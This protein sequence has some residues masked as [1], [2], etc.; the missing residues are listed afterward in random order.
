M[1][2]LRIGLER[3]DI[4]SCRLDGIRHFLVAILSERHDIA[5][6]RDRSVGEIAGQTSITAAELANAVT[7]YYRGTTL[8]PSALRFFANFRLILLALANGY[9]A[10]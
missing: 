9:Q 2:E 8:H 7:R 5:V 6:N 10:A 3:P 4:D 1:S